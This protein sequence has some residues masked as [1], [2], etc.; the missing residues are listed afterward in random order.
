MQKIIKLWEGYKYYRIKIND[1]IF[2]WATPY[3]KKH[4]IKLAVN[5]WKRENVPIVQ[6]VTEFTF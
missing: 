5:Q 3:G 6:S 4:A 1:K 2:I